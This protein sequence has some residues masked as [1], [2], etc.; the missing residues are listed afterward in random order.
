MAEITTLDALQALHR[1][2]LTLSSGGGSSSDNLSN[3]LLLEIFE[4][5]LG[6]LWERPKKSEKSRTTVKT[7]KVS[8]DGNEYSVNDKFQQD[9]FALSDEIDLDE[10]EAARYLLDS[11][12]DVSVLGR[13][14]LECAVIRFHQQRKY[15][16]DSFRLFLELNN[17]DYDGEEPSALEAIKVYVDTR[18]LRKTHSGSKR[19]ASTCLQ[20][21][22]EIKSWLQKLG[23][24]MTAAQTLGNVPT[25]DLPEEL[26]TVEFSRVSLIQQHEALGVILC[27]CVDKRQ[28]ETAE[29]TEF[30]SVLKRWDKYDTLLVHLVP[31]IGAYMS[32]FAS[33]EGGYDLRQGRELNTKIFPP[34]DDS[35]WPLPFLHATVRAWWLAEYSGWYLDDPPESAIPPGT[36]LDEEDRQR[37]KQFLDSLK[38]GA[39]DFMLSVAGDIRS[40]DWHDSVRAGMRKWLQRKSSPLVSE[41][42]QFSNFFQLCLMSQLEVFVDAFITNLPDVLRK[43]RV[44]EDEQRQLSQTHEQDLDL[45]RFLLIIAY[46]Y[47]GRPDASANF[48]QD[49]DS[50]LAGFMHWASRRA[51]T[52]LVAAFCEM[53]QAISVNDEC[54]TAA[55]E[56]LLDEGHHSSGKMRRTQSLTWA[57]IFKE[58]DFFSDKI[59]QKP[60]P[61]QTTRFR[62]GKPAA[63]VIETEPE[64]S[65]MLECYL[66]LITKLASESEITRQFLLLN[67]GYNLVDMLYELASSPIPSQLRGC[68]FLALKSLVSRKS[69]QENHAMWRC[70]ENWISGGYVGATTAG[71]IRSLQPAPLVSMDRIFDE[72]SNGFEDPESFIRLLLELVTPASDSNPL[73]DGLPFPENLGASSRAPG[74]EV[75]I[76]FVIGL[77]FSS[78]IQDLQD[79]HQTRV[80]RLSCL[81]FILACLTTFN[82]DLLVLANETNIAIDSLVSTTDLATYVRMHP[83]ARVMEWMFNDKV[84]TALFNTIHQKSVDIGNATPDSPLILGVLRAIEVITKVLDLETTY[85][86]LVRP[87]IKTQS[88][89]RRQPVANAAYASFQDGLVTRLNLVV[90]LGKYCGIGHP[91]LTLACLKLLEK[92]SSSSKITAAW[93]GTSRHAHR[94]KAIV[95]MEANGEHE[96]ISRAFIA[97]V[98][99]P[100]EAVS[101]ADSPL[102]V[103]KVYILDFLYQCLRMTPKEPTIAHL[104]LGFK[105]GLDSLSV[106]VNSSFA[107]RTSLFHSILGLLLESPSNDALGGM[108]QWLIGIK[109]RVMRILNILWSSPLSSA[110]VVRELRENELLFHLLTRETVIQ[111]DLS[112]EGQTVGNSQFPMTD[113]AVTLLEFLTLRSMTM[114]YIAMELCKIAQGRMPGVKRRIFDALNGQIVSESNETIQTPTVFDLFDFLLPDGFWEIPPPSIQFYKDLDLSACLEHDADGNQ[115]YN[116]ERVREILL[117][118]RGEAQQNVV[119]AANDMA[120]IE[121]EEV[122]IMEYLISSDRQKQIASQCLRVL[123]SWIKVLLVM[124]ESCDYKGA[125]QTSFFLQALQAIL[126]SLEMF[127]SDRPEEALELAKLARVLLFK[128]DLSP[129]STED[130]SNGTIGN[131]VSDKLYQLFQTCLQAIGKWAGSPQLRSVYYE[132]CYRYLTGMSEDVGPLSASRP[133]TFKTVQVYGERLIN[134]VCD[135]AYCGEPACQTSALIF[136]GALVHMDSQE[137]ESYIVEALNKLN[138][139]GIL[140]DSLRNI[141]KEWHDVFASNNTDQQNFQNARLSIILQLAQSRTGAKYIL[142]ANLFRTLENSGLF[143]ADPELQ[144]DAANP[145]ALEQHYDLLARVVR[146]IGAAILSRGNNNVTQGRKFLTDHRMLVSHAL[147]R[148]AGIGTGNEDHRLEERIEELADALVVVIAATSF[149]EFENDILP[150]PKQLDHALFH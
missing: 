10:V 87:L 46:A 20:T 2:L 74:I 48:W 127:A 147:K 111:P 143:A 95:A 62:G 140:I 112:W 72:M 86:D 76:D 60:T 30:I 139:I 128:L 21:M 142:H 101:G 61:A 34:S 124:V 26:E 69:L 27:E 22:V 125:A 102:Y 90:D 83:F 40:P 88:G 49:P 71:T 150:E 75:Y 66:R 82:E 109:S 64:S 4:K 19:L 135:D 146:I 14:L 144:I 45:E 3:E 17:Q 1:E 92:M 16:L 70:L 131:L 65:M 130:K 132:I 56:F 5:E 116:L 129:L 47:E 79:V 110:I 77:V 107:S 137:R 80:L 33:S 119:I 13:S 123:R 12:D 68:V 29:F 97:E 37:S 138:F 122:M 36:D 106:E 9:V 149:L 25:D 126:P 54:A 41:R 24:K 8:I 18:L 63:D 115:V 57:Q 133:K 148:S 43:L 6:R 59:K 134:V 145:R 96:G 31:A 44:E 91:D 85:L 42:T 15:A 58:L 11:Q 103:T 81:E 52:P 50:N 99:T 73:N 100:L 113:G 89:S 38:D 104:L 136:L 117:L 118:K 32:V 93:S 120:L 7:G 35:T 67:S 105:C 121:R 51:S 114:E 108:R 98:M 94:N 23:E 84:M 141:M 28:A 53:L 78:K 39:F 55:H